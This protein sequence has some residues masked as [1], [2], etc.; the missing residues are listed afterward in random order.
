MNNV[1]K[2]SEI[3]ATPIDRIETGLSELDWIY[4][5]TKF[6]T[7]NVWGM[8]K[9]KISIWSGISGTGKSR[10][11]IELAKQLLLSSQKILYF[12]TESTLED[13]AGWAKA[14]NLSPDLLDRFH[15]SSSNNIDEMIE[16]IYQVNPTIV[17][18]DSANEI[19]EFLNGTK[20]EARRL[21]NGIDGNDGLRD[22]VNKAGCHI[23]LLAQ[24]NGD[25]SIKG[26]TSLPHLVDIALD[27][28]P[29]KDRPDDEFAVK[30]GV[31]HR[32]GKKGCISH[33]KH[34]DAGVSCISNNRLEDIKWCETNNVTLNKPLTASSEDFTSSDDSYCYLQEIEPLF[35]PE[36]LKEPNK[37]KEYTKPVLTFTGIPKKGGIV[38]WLRDTFWE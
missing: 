7:H 22:V 17:F 3:R 12:Q 4:G 28:T 24:L 23:I 36:E 31:K 30:V 1:K 25:G 15:C 35:T 34:H 29:I 27:L 26:G 32:Y 18:V 20:K 2:L 14:D 21:V 37:P 19:V 6:P 10:L 9:G 8:P 16:I 11:A 13:F 5:M 33:W 38:G